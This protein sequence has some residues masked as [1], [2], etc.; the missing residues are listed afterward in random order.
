M[1]NIAVGTNASPSRIL[2]ALT[3]HSRAT[4]MASYVYVVIG[5]IGLTGK[6]WLV[7]RLRSRGLT[8][9]EIMPELYLMVNYQDNDNHV[10]VDHER[11]QVLIVL[12]KPISK[13]EQ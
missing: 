13:G 1:N 10:F 3:N 12:N 6:S 8:A 7:D 11:K 5:K 9:M 4:E 2:D